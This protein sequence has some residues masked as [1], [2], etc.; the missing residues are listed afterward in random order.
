MDPRLIRDC[1]HCGFCLPTCPTYVL[2]AE[3]M[4]S[5]RG[6]I[7]LMGQYLE[8]TPLTDEMAGHFDA[9]LG[10]LACVTACPSG[11]RY[12]RLIERTRAVV[13]REHVR[14]PEDRA[15]RALVFALFP[16]RR[17]LRAMRLPMRLSKRLRPFLERVHPALGAMA[18]LAPGTARPVRLPPF[19]RARGPVRARVGLLTGC[20]QGEFFPHVN[21][22]TARVL[23]LEGCD[24]VIPPRQGCCGALSLHS[25]REAEAKRFAKRTIAVFERAGVDTVVVNAAGCG[26]TMKEYAELLADEPGWAARA[27]ALRVKD[28]AEFLAELGPVAERHPLD[29]SVAYHDACHLAHAQRIRSQ[30]RELLRAIPGLRLV[31][32]AEAEICCGSAG[33]YNLFQPEAARELGARK[34]GHVLATGADLLVSANPGCTLQIAAAVRR[35]G[36]GPLRVAHTAEVLDASLRGRPAGSLGRATG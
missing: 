3:E 27:E 26:S 31:E 25:G 2:W 19:V 23:A 1:V 14:R 6:R 21:A 5:P 29:L 10:C 9:C 22:A 24:V 28:L 7:H 20:V 15:I 18:E 16:Y 34:A 35:A 13:E 32:I 33:T 12:D 36:K 17:R 11:V 4:D 30:P 8:G